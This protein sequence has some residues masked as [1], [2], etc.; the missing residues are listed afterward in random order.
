[1]VSIENWRGRGGG[2]HTECPTL[3]PPPLRAP[4]DG[5]VYHPGQCQGLPLCR[6]GSPSPISP[7]L[8]CCISQHPMPTPM[9]WKIF[10]KCVQPLLPRSCCKFL[11]VLLAQKSKLT[12]QNWHSRPFPIPPLTTA[13][14]ISPGAPRMPCCSHTRLPAAW[15]ALVMSM[16]PWCEHTASTF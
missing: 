7:D 1:M 5:G 9:V 15:T 10:V 2:D 13:P 3:S 16:C 14:D 4:G 12:L 8:G 11:I 6:Q